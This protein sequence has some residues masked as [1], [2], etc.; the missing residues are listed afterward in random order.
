MKMI[1]A[2]V[3]PEKIYEVIKGLE[4]N[5]YYASTKWNV[6][7]RGKQKGIQV[8]D[9]VYEEMSKNMLM[10]AVEDAEVDEAVGIIVQYARC[11]EHGSSGDGRIFVVPIEASYTISSA[12]KDQ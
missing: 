12:T 4:V 11:G 10:T 5:G 7:G 2:I 1:Y 9:I 6:S 3:R 8:G